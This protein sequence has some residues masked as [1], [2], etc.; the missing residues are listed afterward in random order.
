MSS[1]LPRMNES[2]MDAFLAGDVYLDFPF[3]SAKFRY[4][5]A[6]GKVFRR[7]YGQPEKE[8]PP[9][10]DLYHQAIAAGTMIAREDYFQ[11]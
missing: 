6:T 7:F 4:E 10:S 3:E 8:I 5:K 2:R 9:E 11:D 1:S